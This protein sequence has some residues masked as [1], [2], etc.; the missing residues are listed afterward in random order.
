MAVNTSDRDMLKLLGIEN[1]TP[2]QKRPRLRSKTTKTIGP[3]NPLAEAIAR[4]RV[5]L[6]YTQKELAARA[7]V[8]FDT[9][10]KIEQGE[11]SVQLGLIL[12]VMNY[13]KLTL[14]VLEK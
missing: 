3:D 7:K 9:L 1:E 12:K 8:G 4:Q 6:G 5:A 2:K 14:S 10:R 13:L 11:T